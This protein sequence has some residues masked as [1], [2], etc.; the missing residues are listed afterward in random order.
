MGLFDKKYCDICGEKIGLLGNKKLEDGNM[1]KNC[2]KKLSPWFSD[3]RHSTLA[4]IKEQLQY[5]ENNKSAV[6]AFR[7]SRS[8]EGS[9]N[10]IFIDEPNGKFA[11]GREMNEEENP[12]ILDISQITSVRLDADENRT[13]EKYRDQN[14]EM[15]SYN[16]RRYNYA[17]NYY[18][19]LNVNHPWIDD[20][21]I[22]LNNFEIKDHDRQGMLNMERMGNEIVSIL[23]RRDFDRGSEAG[24]NRQPERVSPESSPAG[25]SW[26][27]SCGTVNEGKFCINCGSPKPAARPRQI[28]CDK[29]GWVCEDLNNPPRFCPMCGD[30]ID[31][32]DMQ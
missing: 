20:M 8:F 25:G 11:I 32:K 28:R 14:G 6:R 18:V 19:R 23:Q 30:P 24:F 29:C 27:C 12:D 4:E 21:Y 9:F 2:A 3:R 31:A 1:C 10:T 17:Y 26:T 22:K 15:Q 7:E 16:P 13:E 5:R